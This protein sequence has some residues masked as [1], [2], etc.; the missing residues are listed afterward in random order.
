[1]FEEFSASTD[2]SFF[3]RIVG[4][5]EEGVLVVVM[6]GDDD[7]SFEINNVSN[8]DE[9]GVVAG[10]VQNMSERKKNVTKMIVVQTPRFPSD[11]ELL[12]VLALLFFDGDDSVKFL[13]SLSSCSPF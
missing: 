5:G 13:F 11:E 2:A 8:G 4:G 9:G 12:L 6:V 1:M 7:S 3:I 10:F